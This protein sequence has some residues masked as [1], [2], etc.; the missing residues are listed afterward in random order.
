MFAA[1]DGTAQ[2]DSIERAVSDRWS[3]DFSKYNQPR[4]N[5]TKKNPKPK[6]DRSTSEDLADAFAIAK[7]VNVE[8]LLR[9]GNAMLKDLHKKEIQVF[10]RVTKT[11][12]VSL[13][14]REFIFNEEPPPLR[15]VRVEPSELP[16]SKVKEIEKFMGLKTSKVT[17]VN[18]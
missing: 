13:L 2:K 1:H 7:I 3:A 6:Q 16:K 18:R 10:N 11:Y 12:P 14:D 8:V 9:S 5:P 15:T 4:A 17:K